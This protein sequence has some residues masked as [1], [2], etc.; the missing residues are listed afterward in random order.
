MTVLFFALVTVVAMAVEAI[1]IEVQTITIL[2]GAASEGEMG[3][4][5]EMIRMLD[6]GQL[7]DPSG[8]SV[9]TDAGG[10]FRVDKT[11]IF[12]FASEFDRDGKALKQ[13]D[14]ALGRTLSGTAKENGSMFEVE[15]KYAEVV[16]SGD[17]I[18]KTDSERAVSQP[19]FAST[20]CSASFTVEPGHWLLL[21][22][23]GAKPD[24]KSYLAV[25]VTKTLN[26]EQ[27]G[28]GQSATA[29]E[30]EPEGE[31]KRHSPS[32]NR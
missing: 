9:V 8:F 22:L 3:E 30:S 12:R 7:A 24:V 4:M 20:R 29:P 23:L 1:E 28:A 31:E 21:P 11:K 13:E 14:R 16:K 25:R 10:E 2:G 18:H 17:V 26:G 32:G 27:G 6:S 15:L 5:G 19:V